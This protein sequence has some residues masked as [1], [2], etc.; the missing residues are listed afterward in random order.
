MT[1]RGASTL[2]LRQTTQVPFAFIALIAATLIV[3]TVSMLLTID[4]GGNPDRTG[5]LL[6]VF[7]VSSS[8]AS[9]LGAVGR[10]DGKIMAHTMVPGI[11]EV[12]GDTE[13]LSGRLLDQGA[14]LVLPQPGRILTIGGCSYLSLEAYD[15]RTGKIVSGPM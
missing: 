13:G 9:M 1:R 5:K 7:P 6:A 2:S 10:A 4:A 12:F 11:V 14:L 8:P 15:K 3:G